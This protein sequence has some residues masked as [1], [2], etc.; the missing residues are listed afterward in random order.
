MN[1]LLLPMWLVSG[2]LFPMATARGA[3][4]VIM[5]ANPLT[6]SLSLLN[7]LLGLPNATPGP[8]VSAVVTAAFGLLLL[9]VSGAVASQKS[10]RSAA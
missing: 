8:L 9:G 3:I 2:A 5:W 7:G 10:A 1:L 4:R 6:Y